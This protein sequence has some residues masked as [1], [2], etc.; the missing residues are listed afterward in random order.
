MILLKTFNAIHDFSSRLSW[1]IAALHVVEEVER[2]EQGLE[3]ME[4][5]EILNILSR[6]IDDS[7]SDR[8]RVAM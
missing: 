2:R 1:S 7:L 6:L 3:P 5:A 8:Q 4:R